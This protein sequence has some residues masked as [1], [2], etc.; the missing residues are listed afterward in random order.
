MLSV[1]CCK[2][3]FLEIGWDD[4]E[5]DLTMKPRTLYDKFLV[6]EH[7]LDDPPFWF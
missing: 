7:N 2:L 3:V 5:L 6:K 1:S 4:W